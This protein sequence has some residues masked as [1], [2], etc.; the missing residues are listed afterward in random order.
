[1]SFI[2]YL[3]NFE[4]YDFF[5]ISGFCAFSPKKDVK[6][7][8]LLNSEEF[9]LLPNITSSAASKTNSKNHGDN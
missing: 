6:V 4:S 3:N 7:A 1:M 9:Q 8:D 5:Q 2:H